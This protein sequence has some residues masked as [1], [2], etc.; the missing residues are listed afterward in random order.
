MARKRKSLVKARSGTYYENFSVHGHRFRG[1][2]GTNDEETAEILAA[3]KRKR[4]LLGDLI[5]EKLPEMT[6]DVALGKYWLERAHDLPSGTT[7]AGQSKV[8]RE[9]LGKN[10]LLSKITP[11][12]LTTYAASRRIGKITHVRHSKKSGVRVANSTVNTELLLLRT[13][14][15]RARKV[16]KVAYADIVWKDILL[17]ET[18]V[19]QHI[20]SRGDEEQR[21]FDELRDELRGPCRLALI[22]GLRL[23]NFIHLTWEQIKWSEGHLIVYLKSKEPGGKLHYVPLTD[24]IREIL[25]AELGRHKKWV[26]TFVCQHTNPRYGRLKG[27]RY[28]FTKQGFWAEFDKARKRAG[29]WYGKKCRD[30]F[31]IHD[32]RHTAATRALRKC[33]NLETVKMLL[34]HEDLKTTE[35]YAKTELEDVRSAID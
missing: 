27:E 22:T 11:A 1:S 5:P 19:R 34:G 2:L 6:L 18:G 33:G 30:N 23:D 20:L 21:L 12:L 31:R 17:A 26:F 15:N 28:P 3:E 10:T 24:T 32:L 9:G 4:L 25:S 7:V 16:W 35:R 29:L 8:L 14:M 13:I